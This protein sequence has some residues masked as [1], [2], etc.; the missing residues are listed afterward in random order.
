M[1]VVMKN[2]VIRTNIICHVDC[3]NGNF[4]VEL[5]FYIV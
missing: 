2:I 3:L 5:Y 1:L 4:L